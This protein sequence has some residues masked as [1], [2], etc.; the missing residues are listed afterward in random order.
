[1]VRGFIALLMLFVLLPSTALAQK[2]VALVI[3]NSAYQHTPKLTNPKNDAT[4]MVAA[5]KKHGFQVLEGFDLD[6]AAFERKV[7]DFAIALSSAQVGVFFYAG[8]GLQVS[9]HNYLVPID[10]QLSTASALDF[11]MVRLDLVHRTME[12][13]AQTNILFLDACRDNPL[14]RNL[15]RAMGTRS[16]EVG[17]GLAQVESGVGTLISFSTQPGNVALDGVGRNSPFAGALINHM[18]SSNDDLGAILIGVRNDVMKETQRKQVPWEHSALTGRFYFSGGPAP[19]LLPPA[20]PARSSEAAE[21]WD[22]AKDTNSIAVLE[23]FMARFKDTFYAAMARDRID[24]LKRQQVAIAVPRPATKPVVP[25]I[26]EP[27]VNIAPQT[28]QPTPRG[29]LKVGVAG[30]F[31]GANAA[32]GAQ[33]KNG[34]ELS[35]A[36]INAKGGVNGQRVELV[37]G[38]D[39]SDPKH[40]VSVANKFVGDGVKFVIGHFSSGVTIAASQVYQENDIYM[41]TPSATD[42]RMTER[43]LWNVFRTCARDDQQGEVA[44]KYILSKFRGKK[45]AI[46]HDH[47]RYGKGLADETKKVMTAGGM[48]EVLYEGVNL[49]QKDFTALVSKI[50]AVAADLIYWGGLHEEGALIVRQMRDQG[51]NAKLMSGD[52]ITTDEFPAI[53][54]P[55]VEGTLMTFFP[56]PRKNPAA[57]EVVKAFLGKNINPEAYTLY[58]YAAMQVIAAAAADAKSLDPKKVAEATKSGKAFKTVIGDLA[59]NMKGD[60]TRLDYVVY[61]WRKG[62]DGRITYLPE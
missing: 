3:G 39:V 10:A 36:A 47:T 49:G 30:P 25:P 7:R 58:A 19:S 50:R 20:P 1:M 34:V 48:H 45:I 23:A 54:G 52:G 17:R 6:K 35:A 44:A 53:G 5:L 9:G 61:V 14:A 57:A 13:E 60:I 55:A 62:R 29:N 28:P 43:G 12:R 31:T 40:G 32:F 15:A 22:R 18:S 38:D 8:H 42:P 56:D 27:T 41:I 59:Y 4:D 2:R 46:V 24:E 37:L 21:A 11:E 26:Q 51:V 16:T 33:F